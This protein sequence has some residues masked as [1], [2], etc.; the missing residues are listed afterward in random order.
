MDR[1][2]RACEIVHAAAL[3][4]WLGA[5]VMT[6]VF[7]A[8]IF[9]AMRALDPV[10]PGY[11]ALDGGHWRIAAGQVAARAFRVSDAVEAGAL[12]VGVASFGA[13]LRRRGAG[14]R[15]SASARTVVLAALAAVTVF[16]VFVL[17]PR[18]AR[19]SRVYWESARAGDLVAAERARGA[20]EADH[21]VATRLMG[22]EGVLL[23]LGIGLSAAARPERKAGR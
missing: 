14:G 15:F 22:T 4:L 3:A 11:A 2:G 9:P 10:L 6:A 19:N 23:L 20:F 17:G 21:P 5:I 13:Q 12:V 8:I 1:A 16:H 7:A 18:M